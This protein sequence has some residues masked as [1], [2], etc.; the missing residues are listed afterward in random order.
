MVKNNLII[1]IHGWTDTKDK[2]LFGR[3]GGDIP[4]ETINALKHSMPDTE[5][6]A[7]EIS[8]PM[9]CLDS[10]ESVSQQLF[11]KIDGYLSKNPHIESITLLGYSAGSLLARR[12]FCMAHGAKI[13]GEVE[14][15]AT[16]W[17]NKVQRLVILA[18]ITR[19]WEIST[20][21]PALVRFLFPI[22]IGIAFSIG[23]VNGIGRSNKGFLLF[24]SCSEV[25]HSQ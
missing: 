24:G 14:S 18:G 6:W 17:A 1:A 20:A 19:G 12:V 3:Q 5:V 22:L 13:S 9:F 23:F 2:L 7:P 8:L 25:L 16:P 11:D 15:P 10:P 21:S 4:Q